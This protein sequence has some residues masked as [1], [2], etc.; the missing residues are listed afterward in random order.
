MEM[1]PDDLRDRRDQQKLE[2]WKGFNKCK[3]CDYFSILISTTKKE[4]FKN[5]LFEFFN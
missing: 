3:K 1:K 4:I 5:N 2:A